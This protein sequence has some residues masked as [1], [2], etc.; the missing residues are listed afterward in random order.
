MILITGSSG[1][2]GTNIVRYFLNRKVKF[3][4]VDLKKNRYLKFKNFSKLDLSNEKKVAKLFSKIKP[5]LV[6]HLAAISGVNTCNE[7]IN[8]AYK[9]NIQ[10]TFN[11]LLNS[12][13]F[14]CK[15]VLIASSQAAENFYNNPSFYALT[16]KTNEDMSK[17][18]KRNFKLNVSILRF[19]NV[20]GP[21]SLHKSSAIHEM[22]KCLK[23]DKL[24]K[25]HGNGKQ[26]RDFIFIDQL[27][28]KVLKISKRRNLNNLYNIK[29]N[30]KN[31]INYIIKKLNSFS[32][33][34]LKIKKIKAP[35]GYDV[36]FF[37]RFKEKENSNLNLNLKR[38]F[39]WYNS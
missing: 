36:S 30:K 15:K 12:S 26:L 10:A 11:I 34:K 5:K 21:Y 35:S 8:G 3:Y 38:T 20:Y 27:I 4:G 32:K 31:S 23:K 9:N 28:K 2:I 19:S 16:K 1:F 17:S 24:F 6:I 33:K 22:I 18:F 13:R 14:S 37:S 39:N 29:T 7:N 25:I